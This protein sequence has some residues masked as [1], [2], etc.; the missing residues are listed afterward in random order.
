MLIIIL[1]ISAALV[2][3]V[4]SAEKTKS[5]KQPTADYAAV[6]NGKKI[7]KEA[8]DKKVDLI[9]NKYSSM[10]RPLEDQKLAVLRENILKNMVQKELLFLESQKQGIKVDPAGV[11]TELDKIKSQFPNQAEFEKRIKEMDYTVPLLEQ[12]ITESLA[13]Q[14]LIDQEVASKV[15]IAD[16]E[17]KAYYEANKDEFAVPEQIHAR[18]IL[19]KVEPDADDAKKA[20]AL[21]KIKMVQEKLKKGADFVELANKYSEGPSSKT[22]GDLGYFSRGQMVEAFDNAAFA[23]KPGKVSDIVETRFGYHLIKVEDRKPKKQKSFEEMKDRI[24]EELKRQQVI[25]Q[26]N[27]YIDSLKQKYPV[28][29]NL[30]ASAAGKEGKP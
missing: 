21:K 17:V 19:I 22:G 13:I 11:K 9:K 25:Q 26:L 30:P 15:K 7:S 20:E 1:F 16:K 2:E 29:M 8:L 6:V 10:G 27:P 24:Q 3:P 14:K 5:K 18:H 23:L 28:E 4:F 12:Q